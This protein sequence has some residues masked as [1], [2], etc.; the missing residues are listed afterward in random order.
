MGKFAHGLFHVV[1]AGLSLAAALKLP[2]PYG[3]IVVAAN[4]LIQGIV[5]VVHHKTVQG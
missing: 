1:M 2:E 3:G 4:S 5:A